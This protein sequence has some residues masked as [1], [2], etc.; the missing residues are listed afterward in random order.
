MA[1]MHTCSISYAQLIE[2]ICIYTY[3]NITKSI[4]CS[5]TGLH[6][7]RKFAKLFPTH[8]GFVYSYVKL[9]FFLILM[10]T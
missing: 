1:F 6:G 10:C 8:E 9:D 2:V 7:M 5:L 3:Q 4:K